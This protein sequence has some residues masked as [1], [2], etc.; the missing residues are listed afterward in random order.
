MKEIWKGERLQ[1]A[2]TA[3]PMLVAFASPLPPPALPTASPSLLTHHF[4]L[5]VGTLWGPHEHAGFGLTQEKALT[6]IRWLQVT[7]SDQHQNWAVR[8]V[9]G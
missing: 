9:R 4:G 1:G 3:G 7:K 8:A 6:F 2:P 5:A